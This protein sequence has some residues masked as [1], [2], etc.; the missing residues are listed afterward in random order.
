[1]ETDELGINDAMHAL[2]AGFISIFRD[3][4]EDTSSLIKAS[5]RPDAARPGRLK[6]MV[7]VDD[8]II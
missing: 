1:M 6:I 7:G 4:H 8:Y 5:N 3:L 2:R